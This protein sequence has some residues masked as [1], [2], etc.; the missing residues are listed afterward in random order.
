L[1][2]LVH[3]LTVA[4]AVCVMGCSGP[5]ASDADTDAVPEQ[6]EL[7]AGEGETAALPAAEP[8]LDEAGGDAAAVGEEPNAA[9]SPP[10]GDQSGLSGLFGSKPRMSR[11][12]FRAAVMGKTTDE[13][14]AAIG[15]PDKSADSGR[16]LTL[17]YKSR[18]H[19]ALSGNADDAAFV[20]IQDGRVVQVGF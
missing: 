11:D 15:R 10:D 7:R 14:I 6:T 2:K 19:D 12:A 17:T 3:V 8:A 16:W 13:V 1:K 9:S 5:S 18:T 4:A 20:Q